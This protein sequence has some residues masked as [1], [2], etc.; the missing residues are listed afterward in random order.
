MAKNPEGYTM[1]G[2]KA[3]LTVLFSDIRGF[4]TISEGLQPDQLATLMNVYL[5]SMTEV[6]RKHRGTL[7]KYIGDAIMAFW[8]APVSDAEHARHAVITALEMQAGAARPQQGSAGQ[9]LART[10][11]R[12]RRQYRHHDRRRHGIAGAQGLHR[13]GRRG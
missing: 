6:V 7:D 12:R 1:D 11:D 9:G 13:D 8:G 5:G 10:Q 4:T 3:E 2:R